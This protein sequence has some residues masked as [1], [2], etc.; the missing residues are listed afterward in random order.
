[1]DK[2]V[3]A[4]QAIAIAGAGVMTAAVVY[5]LQKESKLPQELVDPDFSNENLVSYGAEAEARA[6]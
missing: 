6:L 5:Y 1:M 4:K 3:T 2:Y